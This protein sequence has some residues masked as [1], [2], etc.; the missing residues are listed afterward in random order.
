MWAYVQEPSKDIVPI[1]DAFTRR[2]CL[3]VTASA[4]VDMSLGEDARLRG[5][6]ADAIPNDPSTAGIGYVIRQRSRL[7]LRVRAGHT[8][9]A[10]LVT[11]IAAITGSDPATVDLARPDDDTPPAAAA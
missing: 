5:A 10:H 6:L 8:T 3:R 1:R 4:H 2:M 9:D 11:M 7:P